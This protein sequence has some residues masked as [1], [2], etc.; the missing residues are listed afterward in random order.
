ILLRKI[1]D[2]YVDQNVLTSAV[3]NNYLEQAETLLKR[4]MDPNVP[5]SN[6]N[7]L[8]LIAVSLGYR[9]MTELLLKYGANPNVI[10]RNGYPLIFQAAHVGYFGIMAALINARANLNVLLNDRTL[11]EVAVEKKHTKLAVYYV[12]KGYF[13]PNDISSAKETLF[14]MILDQFP[15]IDLVKACLAVKDVR[16]TTL[17][18]DS[19][20]AMALIEQCDYAIIAEL[21]KSSPPLVDI[22]YKQRRFELPE[23]VTSHPDSENVARLFKLKTEVSVIKVVTST[24]PHSFSFRGK[25][26]DIYLNLLVSPKMLFWNIKLCAKN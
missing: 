26:G 12:Q 9:A 5:T 23:L 8:L 16:L 24:N 21:L 6:G 19:L 4:P 15:H 20:L 14:T 1:E 7:S 18:G 11:F 25:T 10:E 2:K 22:T 3:Y 17:A 13:S